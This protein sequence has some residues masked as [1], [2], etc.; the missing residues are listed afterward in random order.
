MP[1]RVIHN[2]CVALA[3]WNRLSL[4]K[5][6]DRINGSFVIEFFGSCNKKLPGFRNYK[7][8]IGGLESSWKRFYG[9]S[10]P[11]FKPRCSNCCL[12]LKVDFILVNKNQ[13]VIGF[14]FG[15]FFLKVLRSSVSSYHFDGYG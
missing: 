15:S 8:A 12:N 1:G 6:A 4:K 9:G 11:L 7:A 10:T 3:L 13:F 14:Y 2:Q 5:S